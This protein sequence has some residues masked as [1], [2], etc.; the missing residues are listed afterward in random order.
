VALQKTQRL[1][2]KI[3]VRVVLLHWYIPFTYGVGF[4]YE[5]LTWRK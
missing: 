2:P 4:L 5:R 1:G 3:W